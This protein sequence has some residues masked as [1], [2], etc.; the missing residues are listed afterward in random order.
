[1]E[2]GGGLFFVGRVEICHGAGIECGWGMG[3][4]R[5]FFVT[6]KEIGE[7]RPQGSGW[8]VVFIDAPLRSRLVDNMRYSLGIDIGGTNV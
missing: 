4:E 1:V 6:R 5:R 7:P 3:S 8:R 2:R